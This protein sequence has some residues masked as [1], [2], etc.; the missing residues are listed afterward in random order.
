MQTLFSKPAVIQDFFSDNLLLLWLVCKR[1]QELNLDRNIFRKQLY[2][3][4]GSSHEITVFHVN[5]VSWLANLVIFVLLKV[6]I[7]FSHVVIFCSYGL[8]I[9]NKI[10]S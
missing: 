3:Q 5:F 10:G 2:A 6:R 8:G 7:K 9:D 4:I 1:K